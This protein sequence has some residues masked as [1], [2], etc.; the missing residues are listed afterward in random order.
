MNG[1]R[2]TLDAGTTV[3]GLIEALELQSK[4]FAVEVNHEIVRRSEIDAR[5]LSEHDRVEIVTVVGGG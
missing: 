2:V 4:P 5:V 3:A 1:T